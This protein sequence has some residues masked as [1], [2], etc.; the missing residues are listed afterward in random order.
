MQIR[1]LLIVALMT[2]ALSCARSES[3]D[4]TKGAN[5]AHPVILMKTNQ[6]D[7]KIELFS[8][9]AP[10]T[11]AN[12]LGLAQ[13]TAEWTDPATGQ[14]VKRPFYDGLI[15]HRVIKDFMIQGG[16]P[17]GDGTGGPGYQFEDETYAKGN[18]ITGDMKTDEDVNAM[19]EALL[20]LYFQTTPDDKK[21]P[22]LM[23]VI[24]EVQTNRSL[25]AFRKH[26][27][28]W[29]KQKTGINTPVFR[30]GALLAKVE[31]GDICMANSGPNTNGSQFFIVTRKDGCNWLDGRHTVFG[32]VIKGMEIAEKINLVETTK[33]GDKPVQ[34]VII[35]KIE[36]VSK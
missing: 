8:D 23:A 12:F 9:I 29:Y 11:V 30:K 2:L 24:Q 27:I 28:E 22:E 13:G 20:G 4:K 17:K 6:G 16:C 21:D 35:Q 7:M 5:V 36:V 18:E 33:P 25:E 26:P 14:K 15:F 10:K 32:K 31:Y 3:P 19:G 34:P 1:I